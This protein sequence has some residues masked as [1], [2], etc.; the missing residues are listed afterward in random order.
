MVV[1]VTFVIS[2]VEID[3]DKYIWEHKCLSSWQH[4]FWPQDV[5]YRRIPLTYNS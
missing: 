5:L 3:K 1:W 4:T 2:A